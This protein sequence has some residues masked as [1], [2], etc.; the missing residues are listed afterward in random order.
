MKHVKRIALIV[1]LLLVSIMGLSCAQQGSTSTGPI[2]VADMLG[3][4]V[5]L[6]APAKKVVAINA[7]DCEIL[8]YIGVGDTLIGR[9]EYCNYPE[10]VLNVPAVQSGSETNIEQIIALKPELVIMSTMAQKP[11]QAEMLANAGIAVYISDATTIEQAYQNIELIGQLTGK[12]TEAEAAVDGMKKS[13]ASISE[14]AAGAEGKTVYF[15]VSP[16]EYGLWTAGQGTFMNEIATLV[17]L[18]N[19]FADVQ[20]WG[21]IS[22]EQV[23]ARDPDYIVTTAMY[24]GEGM[25]PVEE[26]LSRT[27]WQGMKA[28]KNSNVVNADTDEISRPGPRLVDAAQAI[29]DFIYGE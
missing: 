18:T 10:E 4:E 9:G 24:F 15:E 25:T 13:F 19:A 6:D 27:A 22:E 28:I 1:A 3:R 11:E 8:Y 14:K 2:V 5:K 20:G 7:A 26:I 23:L 17:G 29:S 21:E 16:L 12:T